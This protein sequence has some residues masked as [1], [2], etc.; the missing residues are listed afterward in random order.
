MIGIYR[1]HN[2]IDDK[3]YI[4]Q[5]VDIEA[6]LECHRAGGLG[7][8]KSNIHLQRAIQKYGLEN[9]EFI[10]LEE[11]KREE[12]NEKE[13]YYIELYDSF[14]SGYNMTLG[15]KGVLGLKKPH[16]EETKKKLSE[17]WD[18]DKHIT[19]EFR[20]K[21]SE[22]WSYEKH[23]TPERIAKQSEALKGKKFTEEH[24]ANL[25]AA[26]KRRFESQEERDL[27]SQRFKDMWNSEEY[28]KAHTGKNHVWYGK[29]HTKDSRD[30]MSKS[31]SEFNTGRIWINNGLSNRFIK[32]EEFESLK[33]EGYI[34]GRIMP[35]K[36]YDI[37]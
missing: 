37:V 10:V 36:S 21:L 27:Q 20:R 32:P 35:K 18:Y 5:S 23:V 8:M 11:C 28:R 3:S 16:S 33:S 4:G 17:S 25:A 9:F 12:L 6:R 19:P 2:L 14:N 13:M 24:R 7:F 15:G 26:N 22:S 30:K 1:I 31:Q 29:K 34:K